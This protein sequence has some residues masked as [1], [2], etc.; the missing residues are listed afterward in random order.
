MFYLKNGDYAVVC[1]TEAQIINYLN[2][3]YLS[4][5]PVG[6]APYDDIVYKIRYIDQRTIKDLKELFDIEIQKIKISEEFEI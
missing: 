1:E 5:L 3:L 4:Y 2:N 6:N